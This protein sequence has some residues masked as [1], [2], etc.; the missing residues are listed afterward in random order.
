MNYGNIQEQPKNNM[1]VKILQGPNTTLLE[2]EVNRFLEEL[3][4]DP[5]EVTFG[6]SFSHYETQH[7]CEC[8]TRPLH[9][10]YIRYY[11]P[12]GWRER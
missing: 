5:L 10:A 8:D 4:H 2:K 1:R 7:K 6:T 11:E 3:P 12:K 9:V